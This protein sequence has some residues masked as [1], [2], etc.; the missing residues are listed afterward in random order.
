MDEGKVVL[1]FRI[2]RL[3]LFTSG[4]YPIDRV[5]GFVLMT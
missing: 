1:L 5:A 2:S 4:L 3:V